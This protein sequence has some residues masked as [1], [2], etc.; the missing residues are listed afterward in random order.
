MERR[1]ETVTL[2]SADKVSGTD[3]YNPEGES[4]GEVK[5]VMLDKQSGRVAYAIMSYGGF[6]GMGKDYFPLPWSTLH[7]DT[8]KGGYVVNLSKDQLK[9]G[10]HYEPAR[11]PEW[12]R[13]YE[14]KI[15][16]YYKV[17]PYWS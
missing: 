6:I 12:D 17:P 1:D 8:D 16:D 2:I 3:V 9:G 13:A 5:D 14:G 15:H 10:P 7:Y 11:I 4:L